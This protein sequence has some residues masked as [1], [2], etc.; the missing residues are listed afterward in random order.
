MNP[1]PNSGD[2]ERLPA[3][4]E[5]L[6]AADPEEA[7][8]PISQYLW[9]IKRQR[10]RILGFC[11]AAAVVTV[12]ISARLTP[13]F[14]ST[15]TVD[16]DRHTPPGVVGPEA[17]LSALNDADQFLAT[18]M[19][20]VQSDGVLRPVE[21]RFKLRQKEGQAATAST[22]GE[23]APIVLKQLRVTRPPNT[24]LMLINYRS[25]DPQLAADAA[26]AIA[27]SYLE[28]SY[29]IRIR[30]SASLSTF[31]ERQLEELKAKM[32]RSSL[33]LAAFERELSVINPEEKT[34]ILGSRLVQ[35][36][37][38]HTS[39]QSDRL[40]KQA[41]WE[42][43]QSGTFEA[44]L[45][46]PQGEALRKLTDHLQEAREHFADVSAYY[47]EN[48]PEYRR[49][50]AQI[51]QMETALEAT[52]ADIARRV[53]VEFRESQRREEMAGGAVGEAKAE[54]DQ[55]NARSFE[56]QSAKREADA[57]K[58]LYAELV[59]KI[60]EAGINAGF[61]NSA[62]RIA[63][64]A[65]PA[66]KAVSPN[67]PLNALLALLFSAL[68]AVGAAVLSDL[69]DKTVRDPEQVARTLR[70]EVVGSL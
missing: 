13:I 15:T 9:I 68:V 46:A 55:V 45:A 14:E 65:R 20:L 5:S 11:A 21:E 48:H 4:L 49:A 69:L 47:G 30:S 28:H 56:Y 29:E 24:Y 58:T 66:L 60:K 18:Q 44:A 52:R 25:D 53:E 10:W 50:Q 51:R 22:R 59:R 54:F 42:S 67:V 27:Q 2:P 43:I 57:D 19:K 7:R 23:T 40:R 33:A 6:A 36:N 17:A 38:E 32:E 8:I 37:T 64:S 26:N 3:L 61:Q 62:I 1:L 34:N 35:L 70:A 63:D 31:M 41:A 16:V 39:A 12:I